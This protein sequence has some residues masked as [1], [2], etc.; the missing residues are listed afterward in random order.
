MNKES[1]VT[2]PKDSL[3]M[4]VIH[5]VASMLDTYQKKYPHSAYTAVMERF[6]AIASKQPEGIKSDVGFKWL[7]FDA[8]KD[9]VGKEVGG[10]IADIFINAAIWP[11]VVLRGKYM[12]P[13]Y[14]AN[15]AK[16]KMPDIVGIRTDTALQNK[17]GTININIT[18]QG[19]GH[20]A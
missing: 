10:R 15:V 19:F 18:P 7:K 6:E 8:M 20:I 1:L 2:T 11:V 14:S 13:I 4:R 16:T 3:Q 5:R 12:N 17:T 9:A